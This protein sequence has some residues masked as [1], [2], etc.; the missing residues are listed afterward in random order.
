[1]FGIFFMRPIKSFQIIV[2]SAF[3][4]DIPIAINIILKVLNTWL[5]HLAMQLMGSC[6]EDTLELKAL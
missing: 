2:I 4:G 1:M 6:R 3:G 5:F